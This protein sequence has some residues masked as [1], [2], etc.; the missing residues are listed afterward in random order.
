[1]S[2]T[3]DAR[4]NGTGYAVNGAE[5]TFGFMNYGDYEYWEN[6]KAQRTNSND[7]LFSRIDTT[8]WIALDSDK[9]PSDA[10][11]VAGFLIKEG[12]HPLDEI[13]VD[14]YQKYIIKKDG[15]RGPTRGRRS[16][17][18]YRGERYQSISGHIFIGDGND[19][20]KG[21]GRNGNR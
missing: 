19:F 1:M 21:Y 16:V 4:T 6:K 2:R 12:A 5:S 7:E 20:D 15:E 10:S 3:A 13:R 18:Y 9:L 17:I 11:I 14:V 8:I